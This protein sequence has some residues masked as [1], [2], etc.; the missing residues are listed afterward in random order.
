MFRTQHRGTRDALLLQRRAEKNSAQ[1]R[2]GDN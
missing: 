2:G 1:W